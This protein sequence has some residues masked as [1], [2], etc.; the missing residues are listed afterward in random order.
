M[1]HPPSDLL[2]DLTPTEMKAI[3]DVLEVDVAIPMAKGFLRRKSNATIS[4]L[5][6]PISSCEYAII[7]PFLRKWK[8]PIGQKVRRNS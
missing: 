7:H 2:L 3:G 4:N 6:L 8:K 1:N 5:F